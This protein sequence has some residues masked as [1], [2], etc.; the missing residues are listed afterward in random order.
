MLDYLYMTQHLDNN[1]P[2]LH[3]HKMDFSAVPQI[4]ISW[5]EKSIT[6]P[7]QGFEQKKDLSG[8]TISKEEQLEA[9]HYQLITIAAYYAM[10]GKTEAEIIDLLQCF[11]K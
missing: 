8:H 2:M 10:K 11:K 7:I 6:E 3:K 1:I 9:T 4:V 5:I